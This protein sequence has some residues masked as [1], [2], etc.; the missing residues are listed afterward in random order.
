VRTAPQAAVGPALSHRA[1]PRSARREVAA[2]S[3]ATRMN[4]ERVGTLGTCWR[5]AKNSQSASLR[6]RVPPSGIVMV[7][8]DTE[9]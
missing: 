1:Q 5:N 3:F 8:D 7:M 2:T 6:S 4:R 9:S